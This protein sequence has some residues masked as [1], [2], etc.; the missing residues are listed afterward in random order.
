M[1]LWT[2]KQ[3]HLWDQQTCKLQQID[4]VELMYRAA[5]KWT[6]AFT[7][8]F[9]NSYR[10]TIYVGPGNNGGDGLVVAMLLD[11][12][13]YKVTLYAG[14]PEV[15]KSA[16]ARHY[17]NQLLRESSLIVKIW[18]ETL[19]VGSSSEEASTEVVI[20]ALFGIGLSRPLD[21]VYLQMVESMNRRGCP[22]CS[23][24]IPSGLYA[25][26][27]NELNALVVT[28]T[29]TWTFEVPKVSFFFPE[30]YIYTGKWEVVPIGLA[31]EG[32]K[33]E[34]PMTSLIDEMEVRKWVRTSSPFDHK[35]TRGH[36]L[37]IAGS[38]G[39]MGAA[40]LASLGALSGG[41]GLVTAHVP[42]RFVYLIHQT[43]SECLVSTDIDGGCFSSLPDLSLYKA[44]AVGPGLGQ[45]EKTKE[46]LIS[47]FRKSQVPIVI[48]ADALN[49]IS[50]EPSLLELLPKNSILTP[51]PKELERLIGA[52]YN[53]WERLEKAR[54]LAIK[55]GVHIL[56]KGNHSVVID[57]AGWWT[58][59]GSG[60]S[61]LAKGGSGD[62]L[63]GLIVS[64]LAFGYPSSIALR[65]GV[66]I[67]GKAGELFANE[68]NDRSLRV[69]MLPIFI[70][71]VWER[72]LNSPVK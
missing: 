10:V 29:Y 23:V 53:S 71:K 34:V 63:T 52:T 35:G 9:P 38:E 2:P 14:D 70:G 49:I 46:A 48:D 64:L 6:T 68:G 26:G 4:S 65:L 32:L 16:D 55:Y 36:A 17:Y 39:M 20:D 28:A 19:D 72:L 15:S 67:H 3:I 1:D 56:I 21:G 7:R 30:N 5:S 37:I 27:P 12:L 42:F 25:D 57:T 58:V 8:I 54:A 13:G 31:Q 62:I 43:V 40:T 51:H 44:V 22:I 59:N 50:K 66:W 11:R 69:S 18:D 41:C 33:E 60:S 47:L 24:D 61:A 45:A